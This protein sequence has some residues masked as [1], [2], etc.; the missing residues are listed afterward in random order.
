MFRKL[1]AEFIGTFML[2][3]MVCGV[4]ALGNTGSYGFVALAI[5]LSVT[6]MAFTVGH[7]SGGHFNPAVT[8]G[9]VAGG[10]CSPADAVG[11]II[12]QCLGAIAAGAVFYLIATGKT[13][14]G[15]I[16][17]FASNGYGDASPGKFGMLSG[18]IA[19]IVT[20]A[21]FLYVIMG[22]TNKGAPAGFAPIAIG[23]ALAILLMAIIPI[24]NGSMN[25]ARSL[26]TAVFGGAVA[27][28]QLWLFIVAPVVGAV[29]GALVARFVQDE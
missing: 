13:A 21:L 22:S 26:G 6:V 15:D 27:L 28:Q 17:N 9:L 3:A 25:P 24:T 16:G 29:I 18:L 19:E 23:V 8:C 10:R 5:G 1:A 7:I 14:P 2:V 11:Y 4:G 20:T 12:A